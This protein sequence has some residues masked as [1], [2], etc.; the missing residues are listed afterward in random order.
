MSQAVVRTVNEYGIDFDN[1]LIFN[2][3]NAAYM[4]KAFQDT[5]SCLF[6]YCVHIT[7]HSHIVSLV[8]NDFKKHFSAATEFAK[9]IQNL[10]FVPS[11]RRSRFLNFLN[12]TAS[13]EG[14]AT[15]P[16]NPTTKSW[17]AWFDF[18]IY[19]AKYYSL[20]KEFIDQELERGRHSASSSLLQLEEM[21][22]D[23]SF[24]KILHAQLMVIEAMGPRLMT[25]I[26]NFQQRIPHVTQSQNRMESLLFLLH[27]NSS[28]NKGDLEFCF[29]GPIFFNSEEK[30]EVTN[31]VRS[32]FTDAH[33]KLKKYIVAGAQPGNQFLQEVRILD[34]RNLVNVDVDYQSIN[35][36]PGMTDVPQSEWHMYVSVIGPAQRR[37]NTA[38]A[39]NWI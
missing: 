35:C 4:R 21:Y 39:E 3:D 1:V 36:I 33:A 2:S 17:S 14:K 29:A 30:E 5:L 15:M 10:F 22:E 16:P 26:D 32:A 24:M 13:L 38:R 18:A 37:S 34:P 19:H 8:A 31:T 25:L 20:Y 12:C 28:L 23:E 11:G 9:C 27:A 7:C 6:Q